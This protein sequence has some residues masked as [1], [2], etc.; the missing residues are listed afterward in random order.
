MM[1]GWALALVSLGI[2]V[3]EAAYLY[4]DYE[5][6][7]AGTAGTVEGCLVFALV[8][9]VLLYRRSAH[10]SVRAVEATIASQAL[11]GFAH[12]LTLP[13]TMA[14]PWL[15]HYS[16]EAIFRAIGVNFCPPFWIG[17]SSLV[18][19]A[20]VVYCRPRVFGDSST[21]NQ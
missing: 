15:A 17:C 9:A 7:T 2:L 12:L 1:V 10:R 5:P 14:R 18:L 3:L 8:A 19:A 20:G 21:T 13:S 4:H 6:F 11:L 16:Q